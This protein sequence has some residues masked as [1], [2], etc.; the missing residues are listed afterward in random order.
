MQFLHSGWCPLV[1]K[2]LPEHRDSKHC[3]IGTNARE[4]TRLCA[5]HGRSVDAV[6]DAWNKLISTLG[7]T[8]SDVHQLTFY[9]LIFMKLYGIDLK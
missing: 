2:F 3:K 4:D 1:Q 5:L 6:H 9:P 7:D 8:W